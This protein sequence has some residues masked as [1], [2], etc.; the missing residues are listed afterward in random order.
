M[1]VTGWD[2]GFV[3]SL[4]RGG[5]ILEDGGSCY[6]LR[7]GASCLGGG[8][9]RQYSCWHTRP[10]LHM[11]TIF[12]ETVH[13]AHELVWQRVK[14]ASIY[15][16]RGA[17]AAWLNSSYMSSSVVMGLGT[18]GILLTLSIRHHPLRHRHTGN[19]WRFN[20]CHL[21]VVRRCSQLLLTA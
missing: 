19:G 2:P 13:C 21:P 15:S 9:S 18:S 7:P 6:T 10:G 16:W 12:P 1:R 14:I 17:G 20:F 5:I 3:A 11:A 4:V 8:M